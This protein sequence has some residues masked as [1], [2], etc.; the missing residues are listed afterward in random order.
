MFNLVSSA[1]LQSFP[2]LGLVSFAALSLQVRG[3]AHRLLH[4]S[5]NMMGGY[6]WC[7]WGEVIH[8]VTRKSQACQKHDPKH[9]RIS[10]KILIDL[11]ELQVRPQLPY[12][13]QHR[14]KRGWWALGGEQAC[15]RRHRLSCD[16][17]HTDESHS[18]TLPYQTSVLAVGRVIGWL[19]GSMFTN[20]GPCSPIPVQHSFPCVHTCNTLH[21]GRVG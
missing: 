4:S 20:A 19:C 16:F 15:L 18:Y 17:H 9:A 5:V 12:L 14:V 8:I 21:R 2:G 3:C 1:S 10:G 13:Q 7:Q 6:M 11:N